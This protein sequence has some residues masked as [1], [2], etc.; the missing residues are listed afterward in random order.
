MTFCPEF[1]NASEV[2]IFTGRFLVCSKVFVVLS[3]LEFLV[4]EILNMERKDTAI[5]NFTRRTDLDSFEVN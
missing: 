4:V 5:V 3:D 1:R 2:V